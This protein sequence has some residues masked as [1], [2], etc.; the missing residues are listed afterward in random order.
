MRISTEPPSPASP[1]N[2][3]SGS[4]NGSPLPNHN[5]SSRSSSCTDANTSDVAKS[6]NQFSFL[7][8]LTE[9]D[10][11]PIH[12]MSSEKSLSKQKDNFKTESTKSSPSRRLIEEIDLEQK[13][14]KTTTTTTAT[15][16]A[17]TT[18]TCN[19]NFAQNLFFKNQTVDL[20]SV[21]AQLG[22]LQPCLPPPQPPRRRNPRNFSSKKF[23]QRFPPKSSRSESSIVSPT[24]PHSR[25]LKQTSFTQSF[26]HFESDSGVESIESLSPKEM[27]SS[28]IYS[29][30]TGNITET[31]FPMNVQ[32]RNSILSAL[33]SETFAAPNPPPPSNSNSSSN[34]N[35][36]CN[37]NPLLASLLAD[38]STLN[39][40]VTPSTE[41][42]CIGK[43]SIS[44]VGID[45][46]DLTT[47]ST[48]ESVFEVEAVMDVT[49]DF[50]K[51][52]TFTLA[53]Y[54]VIMFFGIKVK[55]GN[56]ELD[57]TGKMCS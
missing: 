27:T 3:N 8:S 49:I 11:P 30:A 31:N 22:V 1:F 26:Q 10:S 51:A 47:F 20:N 55:L 17:T 24:S 41:S 15:A 53:E 32:P 2:Y 18:T 45:P 9:N 40:H 19:N 36:I 29:P 44:I 21:V 43:K 28:P 37:S 42:N 57:G 48:N 7:K 35:S 38:P 50:D 5:Y 6:N 52:T 25:R 34:F 46:N 33:L 4:L 39:A 16:T 14:L 23:S 56:N 54:L 13:D 12:Q